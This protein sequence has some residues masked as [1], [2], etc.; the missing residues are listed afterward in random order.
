M[1]KEKNNQQNTNHGVAPANIVDMD[2]EQ[3]GEEVSDA[4]KLSNGSMTVTEVGKAE[5]EYIAGVKLLLV[6]ASVTLVAFLMMLDMTIIATVRFHLAYLKI[7]K[8]LIIVIG[9]PSN[10]E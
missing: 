9:Y 10:Y 5:P 7:W 4:E 6:L 3:H 1:E 2:E 8:S